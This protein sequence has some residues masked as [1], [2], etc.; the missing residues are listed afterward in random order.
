[1]ASRPT[2][3]R[4]VALAVCGWR[5]KNFRIGETKVWPNFVKLPSGDE[6]TGENETRTRTTALGYPPISENKEHGKLS[7]V[8]LN[9]NSCIS[10]EYRGTVLFTVCLVRLNV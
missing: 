8:M 7:A 5:I 2:L 1:M 4:F 9:M 6:H 3:C 10:H